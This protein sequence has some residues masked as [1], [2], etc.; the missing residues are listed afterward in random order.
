MLR[1][2]WIKCKKLKV[3]LKELNTRWFLNI[4]ER[5]DRLRQQLQGIQNRMQQE[6]VYDELIQKEKDLLGKIEKWSN[7]EESIW[8]QKARIEWL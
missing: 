7:I 4:H 8:K 6:Q 3:P 5:L 2:V 1:D